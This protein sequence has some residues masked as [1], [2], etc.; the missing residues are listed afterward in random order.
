MAITTSRITCNRSD[1]TSKFEGDVDVEGTATGNILQLAGNDVRIIQSDGSPNDGSSGT[2]AGSAGV[3]SLC[4]D[5]SNGKLYINT[6]SKSSP[7]W[8]VVGSQS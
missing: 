4:V 1:K 2:G 7:T 5:Y 3:G 8:T 6:G